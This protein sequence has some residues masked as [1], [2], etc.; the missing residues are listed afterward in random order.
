MSYYLG[1][2]P[3]FL[4]GSNPARYFYALRRNNDGELFYVIIDQL[5]DKSDV[6]I[7]TPGL[8]EENFTDFEQG[9]DY[10]DG[11]REDREKEYN[12]LKWPQLKWGGI[13]L[14]YYVNIEGQL[15]QRANNSYPYPDGISSSGIENVAPTVGGLFDSSTVTVDST[16]LTFDQE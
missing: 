12:N 1:T 2:S 9:V 13:P 10:Y 11:I 7:N 3:E 15:V 6:E 4:L 8:V 16:V 5:K 14:F